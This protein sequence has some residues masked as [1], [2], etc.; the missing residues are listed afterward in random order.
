MVKQIVEGK[1]KQA[2][3]ERRAALGTLKSLVI[4]PT[5]VQRYQKAFAAFLSYL[6]A[7]K[8]QLASSRAG[9][10]HQLEDYIEH[11]WQEGE[12][13]SQAGDT[14]SSVQHFQPS[15][16]RHLPGAWRLFKAWQLR[17][18]PARA[19]PFTLT[20]LYVLLGYIHQQSPQLALAIYVAFRCL[21][22]TGE[23]LALQAKDIVIPPGSSTVILYLG[24]TKTGQRNP[25]AG[26]VS[27]HDLTLSRRLQRWKSTVPLYTPLVPVSAT[28]FRAT[29]KNAL[30]ATH[31]DTFK[32]KPYSLRRGGATDLWLAT[33]SYSLVAHTGRWSNE[34]TLKVYVQD[35]IALLTGPNSLSAP[36][37]PKHATRT[38]GYNI[39][40]QSLQ[41][42]V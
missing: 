32:F 38:H 21:L 1:D 27:V 24:L 41:P 39:I 12:G 5:T 16:K 26:T 40:A 19:P 7:Q 37:P 15:C 31:P 2:R 8:L 36:R 9:L 13:I 4:K 35:S 3:K 28:Q 18:L 17:E 34:R 42:A 10:D 14:I 11:L 33:S 23:L 30:S 20:T 25:H 22:R 29:F 6:H